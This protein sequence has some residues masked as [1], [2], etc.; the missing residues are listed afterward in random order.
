MKHWIRL[1]IF[2]VAAVIVAVG[3]VFLSDYFSAGERAERSV[4]RAIR[5]FAAGK[6]PSAIGSTVS[7]VRID[8]ANLDRVLTGARVSLDERP[9]L[10]ATLTER[11]RAEVDLAPGALR[12]LLALNLRARNVDTVR[13]LAA[14]LNEVDPV[15]PETMKYLGILN[16][17]SG[18]GPA[19][20]RSFEDA[21]A[22][23]FRDPE[24]M[25]FFG[26]TLLQGGSALDITRAKVLF[27]EAAV[28]SGDF[29]LRALL[30]LITDPRFDLADGEMRGF[31]ER[32][33]AHPKW[34]D[35]IIL[36][37][38][39]LLRALAVR[40]E[41]V[42]PEIAF[43]V[44]G[45]IR[46]HDEH[47]ERD[48]LAFALL[49]QRTER[50]KEAARILEQ[51]EADHRDTADYLVVRAYQQFLE[52]RPATALDALEKAESMEAGNVG[53]YSVCRF[54][55]GDPRIQLA[56]SERE[57]LVEI[58]LAH[59]L[60]DPP[61]VLALLDELL[62]IKPLRRDQTVQ[63]AVELLYERFP[64]LL[65][66]WLFA[67]Q[68]YDRVLE[69][70]EGKAALGVTDLV[71]NRF[72][73]LVALKRFDEA[74]ALL[75][76]PEVRL[77]P[78]VKG[79]LMALVEQAEGNT[80]QALVH[81]QSA[82]ED[83]E[84]NEDT[85]AMLQLG[86]IA[87]ALQARARARD[88]FRFV[89]SVGQPLPANDLILYYMSAVETA[90]LSELSAIAGE[91]A[92]RDPANPAWVNNDVY[93]KLLLKQEIE[94]GVERMRKVVDAQPDE[95]N[96][97]MTLALAYLLNGQVREANEIAAK[98]KVDLSPE[99]SQSRAIYAAVLAAGGQRTLALSL[100][101]NIDRSRLRAEELA[102]IESLDAE[103]SN[104]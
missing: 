64:E 7:A 46:E 43:Q 50:T 97:R 34:G 74:R 24:M 67:H 66:T 84:L 37:N 94:Q 81:W 23:N 15:H 17:L 78:R 18:N 16:F 29:G 101:S 86:R 11:L 56:V 8:V 30:A 80:E 42:D 62:R 98:T 4:E 33:R 63:R 59:P 5:D 45:W 58:M 89:Q 12:S 57:R 76:Q 92:R 49:A 73:A 61:Q 44:A 41:A 26:R 87:A 40:Y 70:T 69:L 96:F 53:V 77:A 52:D 93:L 19:A 91:L 13:G 90:P 27:R 95:R 55:L 14:T 25:V 39:P 65:V 6:G 48:L 103:L 28:D 100:L 9:E 102:L 85:R 10:L 21:Y 72:N 35:R 71:A 83:A 2:L 88:A 22:Q 75:E 3:A 47:T 1:G 51:F 79:A 82:Y 104:R 32:L 31:L 36:N 99:A 20:V 60:V 38:L 54:V 68:R